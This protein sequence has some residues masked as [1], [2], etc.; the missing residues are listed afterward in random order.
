MWKFYD[1]RNSGELFFPATGL[2]YACYI[3]RTEHEKIADI[4][5]LV[6]HI[7][8]KFFPWGTYGNKVETWKFKAT[9]SADRVQ[10]IICWV[11]TCGSKF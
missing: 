10:M 11:M 8:K 4:F 5:F 1:K 3:L 7:S 9:E 2:I 6:W